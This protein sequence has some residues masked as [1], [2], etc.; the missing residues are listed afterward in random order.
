MLKIIINTL[1]IISFAFGSDTSRTVETYNNGN[2]SSISY[3]KDN[4]D[5]LELIK[6]EVFHM[7]GP[8]SMVGTFKNGFREGLWTFWYDNGNKRLEGFYKNGQKDSLWTYWYDNGVKATE[9]FYD[10]KTKDGKV[11]EWHI[12]KECWDQNGN[13]CECGDHWW[14]ECDS[15]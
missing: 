14:S 11:L 1:F 3:H 8:K 6:Q 13:E 10:N 7:T 9:Y 15:Y 2:I 12:D 5:G 4:P